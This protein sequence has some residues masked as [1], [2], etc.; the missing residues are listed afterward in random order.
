MTP[1]RAGHRGLSREGDD[2][3]AKGSRKMIIGQTVLAPT[4]TGATYYS[5]WF[6]RQG[7]SFQV[8]IQYLNSS[9]ALSFNC[10][11]QTKNRE[12]S[13]A[14][15]PVTTLLTVAVGTSTQGAITTGSTTRAVDC[16]ELVRYAFEVTGT[17]ALQWLHFRVLAPIWEPN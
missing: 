17:S 16:L 4:S 1:E 11:V 5:P 9:G 8:A 15:P 6:P 13:D 14:A 7:N 2:E 12:D 10:K 3:Q